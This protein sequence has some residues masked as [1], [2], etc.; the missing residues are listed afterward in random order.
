MPVVAS[1]QIVV[2]EKTYAGDHGYMSA[3][4]ISSA[5]DGDFLVAGVAS[6]G[7]SMSH[8]SKVS[9]TGELRW[10]HEIGTDQIYTTPLD[11]F[12][13]EQDKYRLVALQGISVG[14][15]TPKGTYIVDVGESGEV[16][17]DNFDPEFGNILSNSKAVAIENEGYRV[18]SSR[19]G[20]NP[21]M[22][23]VGY[24][25][26]NAN[27]ERYEEFL[28]PS[29]DSAWVLW[30]AVGMPDG[31]LVF[32]GQIGQLG[33][34]QIMSLTKLDA[35]GSLVWDK[36]YSLGTNHYVRNMILLQNGDLLLASNISS[37]E[38]D[39]IRI[40]LLRVDADGEVVW[41]KMHAVREVA[42]VRNLYETSESTIVAFGSA[43]VYNSSRDV[44]E[45]GSS[46][47]F[48]LHVD[49]GGEYLWNGFIGVE[50]ES[51]AVMSM[52]QLDNNNF[53]IGGLKGGAK[54]F[55]AELD[56]FTSTGVD[57]ATPRSRKGKFFP[58][59]VSDHGRLEF[60]METAQPA[61]LEVLDLIGRTVSKID[62]GHLE[63]GRQNIPIELS[64][65]NVSHGTYYY[66]VSTK[67]MEVTG[68]F[69]YR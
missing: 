11:C 22:L 37:Q 25:D 12:E 52:Y 16:E 27:F 31:S 46:D 1:S 2:W 8:M 24:L 68:S 67:D 47:G 26:V 32:C 30:K 45:P 44:I 19:F 65:L 54:M 5:S 7:G 66:L 50:G 60:M 14:A 4:F 57:R 58:N 38:D 9:A 33:G 36:R 61:T 63:A 15:G 39:L 48:I 62:L 23:A 28:A 49:S 34:A 17:S 35:D 41:H 40:S 59:P 55:L 42:G 13:I 3:E 56:L 10:T 69:V 21:P 29:P 51:D 53:L 6:A 64:D 43:G 18:V 20:S